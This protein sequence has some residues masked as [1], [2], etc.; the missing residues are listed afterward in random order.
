MLGSCL[1]QQPMTGRIEELGSGVEVWFGHFQSLRLGWKPFLNVD[2][3][4]RAFVMSG[5]VHQIMAK[6]Y[7]RDV[8]QSLSENDYS[9]FGKKITTLQVC[10]QLKVLSPEW[11]CTF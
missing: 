4:Q 11:Y 9:D 5:P 3:T 8:G 6:M 1:L 10:F 2:A 7:R